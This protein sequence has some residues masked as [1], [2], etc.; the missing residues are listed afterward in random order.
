MQINNNSFHGKL[1]MSEGMLGFIRSKNNQ[2]LKVG[3]L[4]SFNLSIYIDRYTGT[5]CHVP[6]LRHIIYDLYEIRFRPIQRYYNDQHKNCYHYLIEISPDLLLFHFNWTRQYKQYLQV[7]K[8]YEGLGSLAN[9][10]EPSEENSFVK[11]TDINNIKHTCRLEQILANQIYQKCFEEWNWQ[12]SE[13]PDYPGFLNRLGYPDKIN[14]FRQNID[15]QPRAIREIES[16]VIK[17][18]Y[19]YLVLCF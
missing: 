5:D 14:E 2:E 17:E 19:E 12:T 11:A 8:W 18:N 16:T 10:G 4:I 6:L 9:C 15:K 7:G 13:C 3:D 1:C